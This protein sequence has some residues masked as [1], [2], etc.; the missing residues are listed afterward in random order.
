MYHE[1][2]K[3][4]A[5][6]P[7]V[8]IIARSILFNVLFY[9]TILIYLAVALPTFLMPYWAIVELAKVWARTNLW[10]LRTICGIDV[11][12]PHGAGRPRGTPPGTHRHDPTSAGGAAARTSDHHLSRRDATTARRSAGVQIRHRP[13]LCRNRRAVRARRAQFRALLGA[14]IVEALSG[15]DTG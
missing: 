3:R 10:L 1:L 11:E 15:H 4:G 6:V 14:P 2:R 9:F 8:L 12:G 5:R 7:H 13:P